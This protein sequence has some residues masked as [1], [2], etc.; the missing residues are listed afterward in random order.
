MPITVN[1][2]GASNPPQCEVTLSTPDGTAMT[3]VS[4]SRTASGV[5]APTR[6]QPST[7][8]ASRYLEDPEAP[9]DTWVTYTATM[10]YNGGASSQT[11]TSAPVA[12][13]PSP[14]A[15]WAIHPLVPSRSMILD[16]G[17][18][19]SA[20][21]ASIGALN[22]AAQANQHKILGGSLPVV[23]KIGARLAVAGSLELTTMTLAERNALFSLTNDETPIIIRIPSSWAWGWEDG[24]FA[25]GDLGEGRRIQYGPDAARTWTVPFQKVAA[26]AG[27]QQSD[28]SWGGLLA[29]Y[30]DWPS[31][32]AGFGDWNAVTGNNPS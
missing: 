31:V 8:L 32:A 12:L 9:W 27:T 20:G 18:F 17:D 26:P 23:T 29:G 22:R 24:Y 7:G 4:L 6:V 21:I 11:V 15:I 10:T 28:W 13:T 1:A 16:V 25:I 5:T 19:A 14:A 30:A 2:N 3:A